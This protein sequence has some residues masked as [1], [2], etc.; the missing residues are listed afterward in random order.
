MKLGVGI[1]NQ[2]ASAPVAVTQWKDG[3]RA[4]EEALEMC[5][6][7]Y[8]FDPHRRVFIKPNLVEYMTAFKFSPYGICTTSVVLEALIRY[9]KDAGAKHIIIAESGL[10]NGDFGCST[11]NTYK[12][13]GYEQFTKRFGVKL[14]DLSEESYQKVNLGGFSLRVAKPIF[15]ADYLIN[16]P[17]LKTHEQTNVSLGFKNNKGYLSLKSK[18][19]CHHRKRPIDAFVVRLGEKLYPHLTLIDGIYSLEFGPMHMGKAYRENL[20]VASRD[21]FS[22]DCVAS[23]LMGI[24]PSEVLSLN[25]FGQEYGRSHRLEDIE[26]MGLN[27][28]D[29]VHPIKYIDD[30][31]PWYNGS[32]I[33]G[34]FEKH[35]VKGFRLPHPGQTLCTGCTILYN[36]SILLIYFGSR[37]RKGE[38]YD[39]YEL[40][41]GKIVRPSGL[42]K[43][44][45]LLGDCIIAANR[46]GE[47]IQEAIPIPGCPVSLESLISKF[48]AQGI[49]CNHEMIVNFFDRRAKGY[50]KQSDLY[51][52][53]HFFLA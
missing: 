36:I 20:I 40:L 21:M 32:D 15:E 25:A 1:H 30:T 38:P 11:R 43:K 35:G 24:D 7:L 44:T 2:D 52:P 4:V 9:L 28:A 46:K 34:F 39:N 10:V 42:C 33:P 18:Q 17:V 22:C 13:F 23:H 14:M 48:Q 31:D 29:H 6:A 16:V 50:K 3:G 26:V 53:Q 41:A 5:D 27:P 37:A 45:F 47:G 19:M 12:A 49:E 51:S 8:G